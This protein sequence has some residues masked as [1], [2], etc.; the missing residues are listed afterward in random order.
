[1][2]EI[3][4]KLSPKTNN[5]RSVEIF[6]YFFSL[7]KNVDFLLPSL[8]SVVLHHYG[9]TI[10]F[11]FEDHKTQKEL[12]GRWSQ[13]SQNNAKCHSFPQAGIPGEPNRLSETQKQF[14]PNALV[15]KPTA[16]LLT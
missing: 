4:C 10:P 3:R 13:S 1:M 16:I 5:E 8:Y 14:S 2:P 7:K 9:V 11:P 15:P 12:L 6:F